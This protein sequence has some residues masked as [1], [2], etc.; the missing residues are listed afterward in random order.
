[1]FESRRI[2][3]TLRKGEEGRGNRKLWLGSKSPDSWMA[4]H[5]LERRVCPLYRQQTGPNV[6]PDGKWRRSCLICTLWKC[7]PHRHKGIFPLHTCWACRWDSLGCQYVNTCLHRPQRGKGT[8]VTPVLPFFF[9]QEKPQPESCVV[10]SS[11]S[12]TPP[13]LGRA[14]STHFHQGKCLSA[15]PSLWLLFVSFLS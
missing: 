4:V 3:S 2:L 6:K 10:D 5:A 7:F 14:F 13:L 15:F 8:G 1:M 9:K 11:Q 12:Q